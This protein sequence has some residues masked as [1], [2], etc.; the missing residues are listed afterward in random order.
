MSYSQSDL[1]ELKKH[2][3]KGVSELTLNGERV[4]FRSLSEMREIIRDI[5]GQLSA[6]RTLGASYPEY[7][8]GT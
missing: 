7:S 1:A 2:Y 5:E 6:S 3:A 4:R 8:K